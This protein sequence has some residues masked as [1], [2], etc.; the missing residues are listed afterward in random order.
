M[1][2]ARG[3]KF[4]L[5]KSEPEAFSIDDLQKKG[6]SGWDGVRNFVARNVMRDQMAVDD[7]A[8]FYHS[9]CEPP[10]VVGL[11]RV[12]QTGLPDPTQFDPHSKYYDPKAQPDAPRWIM[13]EVEFVEKFPRMATLAELKAEPALAEMLVTRPV[14]L[15]VQPVERPHFAH[16]MRMCG[17]KTKLPR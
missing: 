2:R 1:T 14:R 5:L 9:S 4:F 15:S 13:V 16:V 11:C 17:A 10:G 12:V 6:R 7:L 3:V 8:F